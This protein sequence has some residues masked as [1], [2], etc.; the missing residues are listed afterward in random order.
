MA[1]ESGG[2]RVRMIQEIML[3]ECPHTSDGA[4]HF[5]QCPPLSNVR[6]FPDWAYDPF[7]VGC[8]LC[9]CGAYHS[10]PGS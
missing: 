1:L 10:A 2:A 6:Y 3:R 4:H 5:I 9:Q 8:G 7:C